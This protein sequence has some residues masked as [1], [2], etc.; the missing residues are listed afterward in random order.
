MSEVVLEARGICRRFG[1]E[2][3]LPGG[4][5][6]RVRAL[7]DVSLG[8][9]AGCTL[10]LVGES[11][12]GKTTLARVLTGLLAPSAG[13][14]LLD[15]RDVDMRGSAARRAFHRRVQMVFQH[16]TSSLNPRKRVRTLIEGPLQALTGA[17]PRER[18]RK[19]D[20]TLAAVGLTPEHA[21]RFPHQLSGGEAQR[22]A[23]ARALAVDPALVVLDEAV[24]SLD[25]TVQAQVL[26]LLA[27][28]QRARGVA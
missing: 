21:A 3:R 6:P 9:R 25:V 20:E 16:P 11:G 2:R 4:R 18:R 14:I 28:L 10:G 24:S 15:G 17:G 12:C 23:I 1:G 22:V 8:I 13:R 26:E 19:A 27:E 7:E 5:A